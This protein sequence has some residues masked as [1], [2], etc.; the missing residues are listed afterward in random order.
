MVRVP[1]ACNSDPSTVVLAHFRMIGIS[2]MGLKSPDQIAAWA[3]SGCHA[4]ID[5]HKD[6]STQL[7]FAKAVF[8]TQAELIREGAL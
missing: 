6:A 3:C 1:D 8:R 5:S 2:G 4:Y 7:M